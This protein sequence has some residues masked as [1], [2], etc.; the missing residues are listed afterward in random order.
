[1]LKSKT[2][3]LSATIFILI[4]TIG[5]FVFQKNSSSHQK[6]FIQTSE[7]ISD[8]NPEKLPE[9]IAPVEK[10]TDP[11]K[12][13]PVVSNQTSNNNTAKPPEIKLTTNNKLLITNKLISWGFASAKDR[14]IDTIIIH[15][16]YNALG[17]D[18]YDV[19]KL[20]AEYKEYGV[21]PHYLIDR[22]GKIYL[23]VEE[24]NIAYHAGESK[25]PD[26]RTGVNSFS[27]GIEMIN[28]QEEK[29]TSEQYAS[30][31][32]LLK[33]I[34]AN[35]SIKY[36]LGHDDIAKGRKTDPWNFDWKKVN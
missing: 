18:K 13:A 36:V 35:Y 2:I 19:A 6:I 17:G 4:L 14:K 5:F 28:T 21:A 11:E 34:K 8:P 1:M 29:Y 12:E 7:V 15:S 33:N 9:N 16:S 24:K 31:N 32:A 25:V 22:S 27:L 3:F 26:G 30:L 20:I 10:N 23:L